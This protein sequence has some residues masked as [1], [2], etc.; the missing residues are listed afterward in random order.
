MTRA[1]SSK[2]FEVMAHACKEGRQA[3]ILRRALS[4]LPYEVKD[5]P[6]A[7][8]SALPMRATHKALQENYQKEFGKNLWTELGR[9]VA[10]KI[11]DFDRFVFIHKSLG[12]KN[13]SRMQQM[14]ILEKSSKEVDRKLNRLEGRLNRSDRLRHLRRLPSRSGK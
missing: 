1:A 3:M 8:L 10:Q 4:Q 12:T 2:N 13:V 6:S 14:N 9:I 7:G 11:D 5:G